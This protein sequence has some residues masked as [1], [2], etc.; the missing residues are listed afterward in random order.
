MI[1]TGGKFPV[2]PK[3]PLFLG[4]KSCLRIK[5][6]KKCIF[7]FFFSQ[8]IRGLDSFR[9]LMS[10]ENLRAV[11]R[12]RILRRNQDKILKSFHSHLY[13]FALGFI[14]LQIYATFY[15]FY[16]SVTVHTK[17]DRNPYPLSYGL[18]NPYRN[19]QSENSQD[20]A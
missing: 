7:C 3:F 18:R 2:L 4:R 20:Y 5:N 13:S 17:P 14:F 8:N 10:S 9:M 16:C 12:G 15:S 6:I 19:L 11:I 1:Q